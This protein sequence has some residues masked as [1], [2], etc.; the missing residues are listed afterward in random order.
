MPSTGCGSRKTQGGWR[1][2]Q[3]IWTQVVTHF[4]FGWHRRQLTPLLLL[5]LSLVG[6]HLGHA[7][8]CVL[9]LREG[10]VEVRALELIL[11]VGN[12]TVSAGAELAE[13]SGADH[14]LLTVMLTVGRHLGAVGAAEAAAQTVEVG[15]VAWKLAV[16]EVAAERRFK[17]LEIVKD[18]VVHAVVMLCML[19]HVGSPAE[20]VATVLTCAVVVGDL[21]RKLTACVL[22]VFIEVIAPEALQHHPLIQHLTWRRSLAP[23]PEWWHVLDDPEA[24][25]RPRGCRNGDSVAWKKRWKNIKK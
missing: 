25:L 1:D 18:Q 9:T 19:V 11:A 20:L 15:A 22:A 17:A 16:R 8:H 23:L 21:E 5:M 6:V 2:R 12:F 3:H 13:A 14:V 24:L 4:L 7:H 10:A